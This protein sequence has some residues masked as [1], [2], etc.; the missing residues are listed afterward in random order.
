LLVVVCGCQDEVSDRWGSD[1]RRGGEDADLGDDVASLVLVQGVCWPETCGSHADCFFPGM[2]CLLRAVGDAVPLASWGAL[3]EYACVD[4]R[5]VDVVPPGHC[6]PV[7]ACS[8]DA[9][10]EAFGGGRCS[11]GLAVA[12]CVLPCSSDADC[13]LTYQPEPRGPTYGM[14]DYCVAGYCRP[15]RPGEGGGCAFGTTCRILPEGGRN[16]I[17]G[18]GCCTAEPCGSGADCAVEHRCVGAR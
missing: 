16:G 18:R 10:C 8:S 15:C 9:D 11:L 13:L 6:D 12:S 14:S 7:D 4:E 3:D 1:R 2:V 5:R 17:T